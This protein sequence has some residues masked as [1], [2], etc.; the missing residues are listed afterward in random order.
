M[1]YT[2]LSTFHTRGRP[3]A[4]VTE[5]GPGGGWQYTAFY[6]TIRHIL[7]KNFEAVH[8]S[9]V[10]PAKD[11]L[12]VDAGGDKAKEKAKGKGEKGK[13]GKGKGRGKGQERKRKAEAEVEDV[14]DE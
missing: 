13:K 14:G 9:K 8:S 3:S 12:K 11:L 10:I 1:P 7:P 6:M 4:P 5:Y 2:G